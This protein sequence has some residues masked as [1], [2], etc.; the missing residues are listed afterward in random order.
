MPVMPL[1]CCYAPYKVLLHDG[2]AGET[3]AEFKTLAIDIRNDS[4]AN[5]KPVP[6][7]I[8]GTVDGINHTEL[9][10]V[11]MYGNTQLF[12]SSR[13]AIDGVNAEDSTIHGTGGRLVGKLYSDN[14]THVYPL[15]RV[16]AGEPLSTDVVMDLARK[17]ISRS[18]SLAES[19]A[20]DSV[21]AN[22]Y[23]TMNSDIVEPYGTI[24]RGGGTRLDIYVLDGASAAAIRTN[25]D[26]GDDPVVERGES[27]MSEIFAVGGIPEIV[28]I[29]QH[30]VLDGNVYDVWV[31]NDAEQYKLATQLI[32]DELIPHDI[33]MTDIDELCEAHAI[34]LSRLNLKESL[35][36]DIER[37]RTED[38]V[39]ELPLVDSDD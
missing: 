37:S 33:F 39:P 19:P 23:F 29:G 31:P 8:S 10:Y 9:V 22:M 32:E 26:Y 16:Q 7:Y 27:N 28:H 6:V 30:A 21:Q 4:T 35:E 11:Y 38:D 5:G 25:K 20:I 18:G 14:N 24:Y 1:T 3:G 36:A 34:Y 15:V 12:L 17:F 2:G 13:Y